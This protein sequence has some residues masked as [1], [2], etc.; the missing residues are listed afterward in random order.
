MCKSYEL[1]RQPSIT[2][3]SSI[4]VSEIKYLF[5]EICFTIKLLHLLTIL[6]IM[7]RIVIDI[8]D[9][10]LG[11]FMELVNNLGFKKVTQISK[12]QQRFVDD[13]QRSLDQVQQHQEGKI[14][15]Q[16]AKDFLNEL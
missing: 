14:T 10:K 13:L 11:F 8:S 16:S 6:S 4:F 15:L 5:D 1:K 7:Q 2:I 12:S 3:F 9:S